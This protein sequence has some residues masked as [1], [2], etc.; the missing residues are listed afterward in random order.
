MESPYYHSFQVWGV[1]GGHPDDLV[2][3][4]IGIGI[5]IGINDDDLVILLL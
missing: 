1:E 2:W 5:G 3:I 4:G